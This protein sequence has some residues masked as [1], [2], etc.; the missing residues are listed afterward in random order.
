MANPRSVRVVNF[1]P[2]EL[3]E[4]KRLILR[5]IVE[6]HVA[7]GQPVGS[8]LLARVVA[9]GLSPATVRNEMA[10]LEESGYLESPHHSAGRIPS[11]RGYRFYVDHLMQPAQVPS[12]L[13]E[14]IRESLELK[15]RAVEA[16]MQQTALL[17]GR[18]TNYMTVVAGPTAGGSVLR[19]I[20]ILPVDDRRA[21]LVAVT[22]GG[23]VHDWAIDLSTPLS[24]EE[25]RYISEVLTRLLGGRALTDVGRTVLQGLEDALAPYR[26][27]LQVVLELL[28]DQGQAPGEPHLYQGGVANLLAHQEFHDP[29]RAMDVLWAVEQSPEL[30]QELGQAGE[31]LVRIRI[32]TENVVHALSHC[33]M[34]SVSYTV[35]GEWAGRLA[36][37]GPTRMDYAHAVPVLQAVAEHLAGWF[38]RI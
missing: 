1:S 37:I 28:H 34:I 23:A 5:A 21:V 29:R 13:L 25:L 9:L 8:R 38:G 16:V 14:V 24:D 11:Q 19:R 12:D 7:T 27:L 2:A 10:D 36:I 20:D 30:R 18:L 17:L 35:N 33:S 3:D 26:D 32:G 15:T 31:P 4:R 6:E 22:G